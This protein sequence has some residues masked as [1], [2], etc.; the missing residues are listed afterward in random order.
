[1]YPRTFVPL[2]LCFA[3]VVA[4]APASAQGS[5]EFGGF[6]S[7]TRFDNSLALKDQP[8]AGGR[9]SVISGSGFSTWLLEAEGA[10]ATQ[11]VG[12]LTLRYIPARARLLYAVP[13]GGGVSFVL[14]GGGVRNDY[15]DG[16][17][18][19]SVVEWGY[20]G[21]AGFRLKMGPF[22]SLRVEAVTDYMANPMN[23]SPTLKSTYNSGLQAG[24]SFPLYTDAG[25]VREP[26]TKVAPREEKKEVVSVD[27]DKDGVGDALDACSNTPAG[28][29]VDTQG[30]QVYRDTDN[31]GVID[32]RDACPATLAGAAIDGR[33]CAIGDNDGDGVTNTQ[34]RCPNSA[35]G[36]R[37]DAMGCTIVI[38]TQAVDNDADL[39]GVLDSRDKCP[40]TPA[41]TPADAY[42]CPIVLPKAAPV[43]GD[44][45]NDGVLD[46]RDKCPGTPAGA[47]ADASGCT[48]L[49][50]NAERTVTL[51]GVNFA[52]GRD[53]LT[54]AS[55]AV[56]DDVARQLIEAPTIRVEI[57][58]H[59]D[60]TG[61]RT[62]NISLSLSR[63]EAVRAY[64]VMQGVPI[65]RL[66]PRG[67]GPD[68]PIAN[69]GTSGGRA[70]NRRVELR[71]IN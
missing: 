4:A 44:A 3:V 31:D 35:A 37:V 26:K 69:N 15:N 22:M 24:L 32:A 6:G 39:D 63:A 38:P 56:L 25:P 40:A 9:L 23:E 1:M 16:S 55:F 47:S 70:M 36:D 41:G 68:Q 49:F 59:T 66:V 64:L 8:G 52:S 12:P 2:T 21:L 20:T 14:G 50:K 71:K 28:A 27:A 29:T 19:G 53:E 17:G 45:D 11:G 5:I 18:S 13:L 42:G 60:A 57:V 33:G 30:C 61:G 34:D 65:E 51:R 7:Y 54:P 67:Y 58:G 10:Y 48:I 62:R 43:D 46:S